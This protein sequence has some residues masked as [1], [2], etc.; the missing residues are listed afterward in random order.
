MSNN[1][2]SDSIIPILLRRGFDSH[3]AENVAQEI[4]EALDLEDDDETVGGW[5]QSDVAR[6]ANS[7]GLVL[8]ECETANVFDVIR[9]KFDASVGINWDTIS[10][11]LSQFGYGR[12]ISDE[13]K[14]RL[15]E[16]DEPII[17]P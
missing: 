7:L 16:D 6:Q 2:E 10:Y 9:N 3:V 14:Q 13:E 5:S 15:D 11:R 17:D 12:A 1:S 8:T 4:I